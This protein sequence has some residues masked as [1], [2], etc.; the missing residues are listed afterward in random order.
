MWGPKREAVAAPPALG[1]EATPPHHH[2]GP[3]AQNAKIS[4]CAFWFPFPFTKKWVGDFQ[5]RPAEC[6]GLSAGAQY[7]Q[8]W[9][10]QATAA[11]GG[12][13]TT[14]LWDVA[15]SSPGSPF[16]TASRVGTHCLS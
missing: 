11:L 8:P 14:P 15:P 13:L 12:H 10:G 4:S 9:G 16:F 3:A 2:L 1:E 7:R 6:A 5:Q